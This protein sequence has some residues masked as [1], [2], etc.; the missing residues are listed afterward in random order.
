[1]NKYILPEPTEHAIQCA[2]VEWCNRSESAHPEL[3]L[4]FAVPN[5]AHL[6][7]DA[8]L[9]A[10]KMANLKKEGF[11]TGV[12]DWILPFPIAPY[13]GLAIEFKRGCKGVLSVSQEAYISL[14]RIA[15]WKVEVCR[16]T[17]EAIS[18]VKG[19]LK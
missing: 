1:M 4:A 12:P 9:R 19:Y 13:I 15:G 6:A 8:R 11:R 7:G 3:L 5:G 14:L 16:T 17:E 10:I 2:F 18:I